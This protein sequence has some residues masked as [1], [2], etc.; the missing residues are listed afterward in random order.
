PI[1]SSLLFLRP[2][3]RAGR[4]DRPCPS[5]RGGRGASA[6]G[7]GPTG[8]SKGRS[9]SRPSGPAAPTPRPPA[10]AG[11]GPRPAPLPRPPPHGRDAAPGE[12]LRGPARAEADPRAGLHPRR[13]HEFHPPPGARQGDC[14]REDFLRKPFRLEALLETVERLI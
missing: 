1:S 5:V 12:R 9:S 10:L 11:G 13:P 3:L 14:R 8:C 7:R 6:A 2:L 4:R